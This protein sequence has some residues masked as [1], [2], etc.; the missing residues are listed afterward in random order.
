MVEQANIPAPVGPTCSFC[1][2]DVTVAAKM[3]SGLNGH[4]ICDHCIK[5]IYEQISA[6]EKA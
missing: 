6:K 3:I 1:G 2:R 5:T 4:R